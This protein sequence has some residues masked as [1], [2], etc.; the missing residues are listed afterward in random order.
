MKKLFDT[1]SALEYKTPIINVYEL[2]KRDVL[3]VSVTVNGEDNVGVDAA[4]AF[5]FGDSGGPVDL[6]NQLFGSGS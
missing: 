6:F 1:T 5:Q 3:T 4:N 2:E